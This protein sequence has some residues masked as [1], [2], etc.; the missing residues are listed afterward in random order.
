MITEKEIL[1][2]IQNIRKKTEIISNP[3]YTDFCGSFIWSDIN[4]KLKEIEIKLRNL[5]K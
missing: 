4:E 5:I 1:E 2:D 3:L